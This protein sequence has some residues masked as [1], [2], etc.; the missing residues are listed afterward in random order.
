MQLSIVLPAWADEASQVDQTAFQ[1]FLIKTLREH[2]PAHLRLY[3]H[4]LDKD[5]MEKFEIAL[6][7]WFQQ[8]QLKRP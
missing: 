8:L 4:W 2:C 1:Q 5:Q 7:Q 3:L 6:Q